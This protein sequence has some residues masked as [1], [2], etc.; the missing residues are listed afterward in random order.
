MQ[1]LTQSFTFHCVG[2][3][4]V[5]FFPSP[6]SQRWSPTLVADVV[7]STTETRFGKEWS[8]LINLAA[9]VG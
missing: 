2:L 4:T 9:D 1:C 6:M 7:M 8:A 3:E 5:V